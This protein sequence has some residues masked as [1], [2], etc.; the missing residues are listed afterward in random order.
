MIGRVLL[1]LVGQQQ[2]LALHAHQDFVFGHFEV[3]HQHG[4]AILPRR[5]ECRFVH[6][7]GEIGARESRRTARQHREIHIVGQWNLARVHAQNFFAPAHIRTIH[8]HPPV[9][10]SRPQQRRIEHIRTVGR[11]HQDDAIVRFEAVHF[12][13]QLVQRL[14]ALVVPAAE[15]RAAVTSNGV[16]FVDE[17]DAGSVL[18]ALLEQV[19]HA[20]RAHAHEHLDEV[21]A[22]DREE[23]NVRFARDCPR[24]KRRSSIRP[25]ASPRRRVAGRSRSAESSGIC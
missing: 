17:N 20:A 3:V 25:S 2:R 13:Q 5:C 4:F 7:V 16:N 23:R 15:A 6:H 14:L 12:D 19:A 8:H 10:T 1:F 22:G 18:L 24:Q 11:G 9:K 21:R